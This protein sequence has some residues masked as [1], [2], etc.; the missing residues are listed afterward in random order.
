M[1]HAPPP[2]EEQLD[3][4]RKAIGAGPL[5]HARRVEG[6]LGCTTDILTEGAA[7]YVLR[8]YGP[9]YNERGEDAAARE[10]RALELVQKANVP[11]PALVW[12]DI[13][14]VF[15]EQAI[16]ISFVDGSPDLTP[17]HPF[18]WAEQLASTL[19]RIHGIT[20]DGD[21]LEL[22]PTGA[23]ED[24]RKV[25]ESPE[26]ILEHPLGEELLRRQHQLIQRR[27]DSEPV[28]SHTDYWPGNTLWRDNELVAV[29][30]WESPATGDRE[31]DV[32]YCSLD[33]RY[34]GMDR[35]ADRLIDTYR[36]ITGDRL[37]N[38]AQWEAIGLCRPMP[39]IAKWVPAWVR[40]GR[41]ID[42][43]GARAQHTR[44]IEEYLQRTG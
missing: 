37:P 39:D 40:M 32:A 28:F 12:I 21:D 34:L 27:V 11:A 41:S 22:F 24:V 38:L 16:V 31:M 8:R 1:Q 13:E 14:G 4:V 29:I 44:V 2:T 35:V 36:D 9:W 23:G 33:I 20:I 42:E 3:R 7:R 6:G 18:D 10:A 26:L 25:E 19:A 5:T 15:E 43:E 30:D 17:S